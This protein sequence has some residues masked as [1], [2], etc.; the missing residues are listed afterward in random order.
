[1]VVVDARGELRQR[2]RCDVE[3]QGVGGCYL[4][5]QLRIAAGE[6]GYLV[7]YQLRY[8]AVC[9]L[10]R[11]HAGMRAF[12]QGRSDG[13]CTGI[14]A[15]AYGAH[16]RRIVQLDDARSADGALERAAKTEVIE[17]CILQ[18]NLVGVDDTGSRVVRAADTG[19][20]HKI[21]R[22]RPALHQRR[23]QLDKLFADAD[24][25]VNGRRGAAEAGQL[26]AKFGRIRL[27]I[28]RVAAILPPNIDGDAVV[29]RGQF[30]AVFPQL[31]GDVSVQDAFGHRTVRRAAQIQILELLRRYGAGAEN[32]VWHARAA[33]DADRVGERSGNLQGIVDILKIQV[34]IVRREQGRVVVRSVSIVAPSGQEI[35]RRTQHRTEVG[36][37]EV[38]VSPFAL[39]VASADS[40]VGAIRR[41]HGIAAGRRRE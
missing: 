24:T 12:C 34:I 21:F 36:V 41:K 11:S 9:I 31:P 18:F 22:E 32:V 35:P 28:L 17:R 3:A 5:L 8:R 29:R 27:E 14:G 16:V 10:R 30:D 4:R 19:I 26:T 2:G 23:A 20:D 40:H 33:A 39:D 7:A 15:E 37:L 13:R 38:G 25:L 6:R 1:M